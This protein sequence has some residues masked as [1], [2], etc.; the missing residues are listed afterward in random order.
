MD[1]DIILEPDLSPMQVA[2]LGQ[3]AERLGIRALW[4]SN[5]FAHWDAFLSLVP[6]IQSTERLLVGPLAVSPFEMHPQKMANSIITL[7]EFSKG[8]AVIAMGA[9]EGNLDCMNLSKPKK[10]V[11]AVREAVEI[12]MFAGAGKLSKGYQ[13]EYFKVNF[14][15]PYPWAETG[16]PFV[17]VTSY[18]EQMQR[19]GGRVANGAYLGSM[20]TNLVDAAMEQV[21]TGLGRRDVAPE[22][23]RVNNFWGWHIKADRDEAYRESR[24]ELAWRGRKLAFEVVNLFLDEEQSQLVVD[25]YDAFVAAWFDRSGNI[26]GI[27]DEVANPIMHG[28]TSTGGLDDMDREIERFKTFEKAGL[29]EISLRLHDDPMEG[30]ELIGEHIVPAMR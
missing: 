15:C 11:R 5:Y 1:I 24:R 30:L 20:P 4:T 29:T 27:P 19:L 16:V 12:V 25:N 6:L 17:Y 13:G 14:P 10:I 26:K 7:N 22:G 3:A 8:R 2:E 18:R 21:R 28:L 23:F 9:G